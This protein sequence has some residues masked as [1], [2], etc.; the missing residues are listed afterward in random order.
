MSLY[1]RV[2]NKLFPNS[3]VVKNYKYAQKQNPEIRVLLAGLMQ[4]TNLGDGVISDCVEY[5]IN[6]VCQDNKIKIM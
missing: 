6:K 5:L 1:I 4:S 2:R 3:K